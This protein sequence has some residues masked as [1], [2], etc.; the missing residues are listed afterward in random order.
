MLPG[1]PP[2]GGQPVDTDEQ[3]AAVHSRPVEWQGSFPRPLDQL[4][5]AFLISVIKSLRDPP[6]NREA[7]ECQASRFWR[8]PQAQRP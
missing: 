4:K 8:L 5:G 1:S 2:A 3:S 7:K 6:Q